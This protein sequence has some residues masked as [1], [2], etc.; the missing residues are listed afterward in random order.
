MEE[1]S[2]F[3]LMYCNI[4]NKG[5]ALLAFPAGPGGEKGPGCIPAGLPCKGPPIKLPAKIKKPYNAET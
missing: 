5:L 3:L 2:S 1:I 4:P